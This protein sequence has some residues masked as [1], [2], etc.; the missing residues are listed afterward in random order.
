M[1]RTFILADNQDIT[2][3]GMERY[4]MQLFPDCPMSRAADKQELMD[5]LSHIPTGI[6]ILDYTLFDMHDAEEL[7]IFVSRFPKAMWVLFSHELSEPFMKRVGSDPA[8]SLLLKETAADEIRTALRNAVNDQR[9]VCQQ[10]NTLLT[11]ST[12]KKE[13]PTPL[14]QTEIEVLRLIA[15]GKSVKEIATARFSSIHTITTHKKNIF[16][17]IHVNNV[18]EATKYAFK[19]GLVEMVEY[20]I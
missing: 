11:M 10:I 16:R 9:F 4:L 8:I 5:V 1:N 3:A 19:A 7:M 12:E 20:Y 6:V 14:T 17:K 18:Y 13:Q 2:R 15:K